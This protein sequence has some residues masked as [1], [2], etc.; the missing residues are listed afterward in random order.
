MAELTVRVRDPWGLE[1]RRSV[2][3]PIGSDVLRWSDPATWRHPAVTVDVLGPDGRPTL[4]SRVTVHHDAP[5]LLFDV[6]DGAV[7]RL[8]ARR[9]WIAPGTRRLQVGVLISLHGH[10]DHLAELAGN[11]LDGVL[12]HWPSVDESRFVGGHTHD[13]LETDPG[14]WL[15]N[16]EIALHGVYVEPMVR[17]A[18]PLRR[19]D[20]H[21]DLAADPVGW[22][23]GDPLAV[24]PSLPVTTGGSIRYRLPV[25]GEV[26]NSIETWR[27]AYDHPH[28]RSISG[29]RVV[30]DR[31]LDWDHPMLGPFADGTALGVEV[32][33]LRQP[34]KIS[35]TPLGRAH[36]IMQADRP[37]RMRASGMLLRHLGPIMSDPFRPGRWVGR[38]GRYPW[39]QH[40]MRDA[41]RGA[42]FERL[43]AVDCGN[44]AFVPHASHGVTYRKCWAHRIYR[45][46]PFWWDPHDALVP[47]H[48]TNNSDDVIWEDVGASFVMNWPGADSRMTGFALMRGERNIL[49]RFSAFGIHGLSQSSGVEWPEGE[50]SAQ[51]S[52]VWV[53]ADGVVHNCWVGF[54]NWQNTGHDHR[55]GEGTRITRC[56]EGG[57]DG[58]YGH[59][60]EYRRFEV[61]ESRIPWHEVAQSRAAPERPIRLVDV[62]LVGDGLAPYLVRTKGHNAPP[63]QPREYV[64]CVFDGPLAPAP[65]GR[66]PAAFLFERVPDEGNPTRTQ[67]DWRRVIDCTFRVNEAW[68]TDDCDP[69]SR[70]IIEDATRRLELR[71][72]DQPGTYYEP[73]WNASVTVR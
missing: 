57:L 11:D 60:Y 8:D 49:R 52:A 29:R 10:D 1:A 5:P 51:G 17:A 2:T 22:R 73:R 69:S 38:T 63:G 36:V 72:R 55:V 67:P 44:H 66:Q 12:L 16:C 61:R 25:P 56:N 42:L 50:S 28:V 59:V 62:R 48:G 58:A 3:V 7:G 24:A 43:V 39:H 30:L 32:L 20:T 46:A 26:E 4:Q 15:G 47:N 27:A 23:V 54:F 21:I 6:D 53:V 19:G 18:G 31:P 40:F 70:L 34:I 65:T 33:N 45:S 9:L 41:S 14:L 68:F 64:R 71:R 37:V 35:G 13:P